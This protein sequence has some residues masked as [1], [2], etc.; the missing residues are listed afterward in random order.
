MELAECIITLTVL[1]RGAY[2]NLFSSW[3]KIFAFLDAR[4]STRLALRNSGDLWVL[5]FGRL[6]YSFSRVVARKVPV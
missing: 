1:P 4:P 6:K 5:F 3:Y 2:S